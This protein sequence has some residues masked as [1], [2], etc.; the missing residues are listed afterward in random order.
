[1]WSADHKVQT[2][3]HPVLQ[4]WQWTCRT[5]GQQRHA[6]RPSSPA[7]RVRG[8]RPGRSQTPSV[9]SCRWDFLSEPF[10]PLCCRFTPVAWKHTW[11]WTLYNYISNYFIWGLRSFFFCQSCFK[12]LRSRLKE[13]KSRHGFA[14]VFTYFT[15][16]LALLSLSLAPRPLLHRAWSNLFDSLVLSDK[17]QGGHLCNLYFNAFVHAFY[18]FKDTCG[19]G[20]GGS[21]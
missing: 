2:H 8:R 20:G 16:W 4:T 1:M 7:R 3:T 21:A 9:W 18:P 19:G 15:S 17:T 10:H 11:T 13:E 14:S 6:R 12:N 5:S